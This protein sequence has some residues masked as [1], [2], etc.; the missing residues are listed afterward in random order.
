MLVIV[1][2]NFTKFFVLTCK[3]MTLLQV[4]NEPLITG[5]R[6]ETSVF[7]TNENENGTILK[8]ELTT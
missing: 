7:S 1:N 2:I 4:K 3:I 8:F 6:T 5:E